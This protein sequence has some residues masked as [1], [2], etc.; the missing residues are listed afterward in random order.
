M[1]FSSLSN[2]PIADM[3]DLRSAGAAGLA[4][5]EPGE[6]YKGEG[7]MAWGARERYSGAGAGQMADM[8]DR[9]SAGAAGRATGEPGKRW[10]SLGSP[11]KV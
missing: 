2:F 10:D 6:R 11:K 8:A 4:T 3:A 5:G 7:G 1:L 9:R